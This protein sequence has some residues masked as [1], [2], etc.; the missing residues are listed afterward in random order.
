M[1]SHVLCGGLARDVPGKSVGTKLAHFR[2]HS[3]GVTLK[4]TRDA[5][6]AAAEKVWQGLPRTSP[7]QQSSAYHAALHSVHASPLL[8]AE[9][10]CL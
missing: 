7:Y 6:F 5:A 8:L 2:P 4:G 10:N 3:S 1:S 9:W